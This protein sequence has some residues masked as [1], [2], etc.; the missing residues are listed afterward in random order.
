[1]DDDARALVDDQ[2]VLVFEEDVQR[3]VFWDDVDGGARWHQHGDHV[4]FAQ[5]GGLLSGFVVEGDRRDLDE[6]FDLVPA[7]ALEPVLQVF[8]QPLI[9]VVREPPLAFL[10]AVGPQVF[11]GGGVEARA[12]HDDDLVVGLVKP[13]A[14]IVV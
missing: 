4:A 9:G 2:H 1:V 14:Q 7:D 10:G 12:V 13:L 5:R 8:V 6:F 3:D 11:E